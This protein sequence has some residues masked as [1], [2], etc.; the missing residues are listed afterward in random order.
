MVKS[1][2]CSGDRPGMWNHKMRGRAGKAMVISRDVLGS[3]SKK[4]EGKEGS[5]GHFETNDK[6]SVLNLGADIKP[7]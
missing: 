3:K 1:H 4:D 5:G 7:Q 2:W 6:Q